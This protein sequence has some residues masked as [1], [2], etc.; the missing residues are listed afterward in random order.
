MSTEDRCE[1]M[2]CFVLSGQKLQLLVEA[3]ILGHTFDFFLQ[4]RTI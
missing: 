1:I 2:E 4:K 3:V